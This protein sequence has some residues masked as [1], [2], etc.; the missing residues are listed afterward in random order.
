MKFNVPYYV[1]TSEFSCG[2]ACV[3]MVMKHFEPN[4]K[5]NRELEFKFGGSA[6]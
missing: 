5:L 4:L 2:P 6:I 1:Q 3:L